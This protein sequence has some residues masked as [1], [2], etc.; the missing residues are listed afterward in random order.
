MK[1]QITLSVDFDVLPE[2]HVSI[3]KAWISFYQK[4]KQNLIDA[5][6]DP[7]SDDFHFSAARISSSGTTYIP[8]F[9]RSWPSSIDIAPQSSDMIILFNGSAHPQIVTCLEGIKGTY[10]LAAT[11]MTLHM[12]KEVKIL[13]SS[14]SLQ[15]SHPVETGGMI[16]LERV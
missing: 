12:S 3:I 11:G 8:C 9:L 6:F 7:L 13:T 10:R 16:I 5:S 1:T 14:G 15:L 2:S 4:H